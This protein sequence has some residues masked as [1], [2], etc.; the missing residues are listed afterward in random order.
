MRGVTVG[1]GVD[2]FGAGMSG[3][4][5]PSGRRANGRPKM[6]WNIPLM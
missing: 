4:G 3:A 5:E 1:V 6:S 2:L